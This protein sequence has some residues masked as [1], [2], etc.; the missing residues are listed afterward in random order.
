MPEGG[1]PEA[2]GSSGAGREV[3]G[4]GSAE[5]AGDLVERIRALEAEA[6]RLEPGSEGRAR[7]RDPVVEYA[8]RFLERLDELKAYEAD[9]SAAERVR[10]LPVRDEPREPAELLGLLEEAVDTPGLNPASPGHLAY[11]PGGG[12]YASS[13]GDYLSDVFNRYSG[14]G[15]A[16]PGAV[17]LENMLLDWMAGVVGYPE[18]CG[19]NLTSGGS[20][21]NLIAVV[22]A[23][24][25]RGLKARDYHRAVVYL[26]EQAHHCVDKA[27]RIAGMGECV[28][29]Y[30]EMDEGYRMR[31]DAL[32]AAVAGDRAAGLVP[33]MVVAS[34]GTTDVGAVDPLEA[35]GKVA[36]SEGLWYH[37]DA[38]YG[39]FF[40]LVDEARPRL[41]GMAGS[42]SLVL[43]PHK[44]LFL[45][46]G[47]GAVLVK[48]KL[49]LYRAH[50]YQAAYMQDTVV[51]EAVIRSPADLSPELSRPFR[52][53][54]LWLPLQLHGVA[55]FRACLEEKLLL[56]RWFHERVAELGYETGPVPELS[57]S[58]Y[59]WVP[60]GASP[61]E[62]DAFNEALVRRIHEDG[63]VFVSSTR[64]KGRFTLRMAA[65]VF[66]THL[67]TVETLLEMLEE[68]RG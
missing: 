63:R 13:L 24:E 22:T 34:A 68:G 5:D 9:K 21:A 31:P 8:E 61:E 57:V 42:D 38:A 26:T 2:A 20:V 45:P 56:T 54:R 59:R 33:W 10:S 18:G 53:L 66:R 62:A 12:L 17:E 32:D 58:T 27:L 35:I 65:L 39:G 23:R 25:A 15:F 50:R 3:A 37:V 52:G 36:R 48:D 1:G 30:V 6:R 28:L 11:I 55:P 41:E 47:S 67:E 44:A 46:Y 29:R 51:E 40:A 19:G 7:V 4:S 64:L 14:V 43:D 60:D 16:G 49:A